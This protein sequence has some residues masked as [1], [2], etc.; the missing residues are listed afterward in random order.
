MTQLI[1]ALDRAAQPL[2]MMAR[3]HDAGFSWF[4]VGPLNLGDSSLGPI[5]EARDRAAVPDLCVFADFKLVGPRF[6]ARDLA[7]RLADAGVEAMSVFTAEAEEAALEGAD[8]STLRVW[9][10]AAL[11]DWRVPT[12][13]LQT[14]ASFRGHGLICPWNLIGRCRTHLDECGREAGDV[15]VPGVRFDVRDEGF[16]DG[17]R[18]RAAPDLLEVL[19]ATHAVVGRPIV[20][21]ADPVAEARRFREALEPIPPAPGG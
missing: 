4:K 14:R 11:T 13:D 2:T 3:L 16:Q 10:V 12:L 17:H 21:A 5:L 1:I 8:G 7:R 9:R 6:D 20:L 15:V 19:G 18:S